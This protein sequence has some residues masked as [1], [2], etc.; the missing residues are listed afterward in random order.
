MAFLQ[1]VINSS[2]DV[3]RAMAAGAGCLDLY[4]IYKGQK[5]PI[6]VKIRH[7]EYYVKKSFDQIIRY[8]NTLGCDK[9]WIVVF[10]RDANI[11]WEEKIFIEKEIIDGKTITIFG[12]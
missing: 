5:Y 11:N 8:M 3:R 10:D 6:E 1:R 4:L 9:G 7:S 12:A 2:G